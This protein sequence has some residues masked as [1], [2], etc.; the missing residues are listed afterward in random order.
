MKPVVVIIEDEVHIQRLLSFVIQKL[1][2]DTEVF[3]SG[4]EGLQRVR[5]GVR[6][7]AVMLDI[8]M[9]G[10]NGLEVL[11][12]LKKDEATRGIPVVMLTA[13]AQENV[14]LQGIK[15]GAIDYIRKPFHPQEVA[16]RLQRHLRV[17]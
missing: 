11:Q 4:P 5:D 16:E 2:F 3:S 10:M 1:G 8:M 6:P 13:M 17:S 9:P 12:N 7:A 14:V 15:L